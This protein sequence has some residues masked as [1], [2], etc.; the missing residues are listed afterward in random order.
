VRISNGTPSDGNVEHKSGPRGRTGA[1][2]KSNALNGFPEMNRNI[3]LEDVL[4]NKSAVKASSR[5]RFEREWQSNSQTSCAY[6]GG[7]ESDGNFDFENSVFNKTIMSSPSKRCPRVHKTL[8]FL[9]RASVAPSLYPARI[10][11]SFHDSFSFAGTGRK[12]SFFVY[13]PRLTHRSFDIT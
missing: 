13:P 10:S 2:V 1:H 5:N 3:R 9:P 8:I 11:F 4:A 6:D 7:P 12:K